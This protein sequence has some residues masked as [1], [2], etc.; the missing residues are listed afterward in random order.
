MRAFRVD[1][2]GYSWK[3]DPVYIMFN[4]S[5]LYT[6]MSF[7]KAVKL[8][9]VDKWHWLSPDWRQATETEWKKQIATWTEKNHPQA[10]HLLK[11]N[12]AL[13][14]FVGITFLYVV[15][16]TYNLRPNVLTFGQVH[17][18]SFL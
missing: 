2:K 3:D 15:F 12:T 4:N 6:P 13:F 5:V 14:G 16:T 18:S 17:V 8:T 9:Q 1:P 11:Q 10:R 7:D